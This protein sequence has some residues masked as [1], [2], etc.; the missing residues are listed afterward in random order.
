MK[1]YKNLYKRFVSKENFELAYKN[2]IK[3]KNK[4][5]QVQ[6]FKKNEKEN[7]EKNPSTC[8]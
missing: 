7:L 3:G 6:E 8:N 1:T 5:R 4:Q 2:A